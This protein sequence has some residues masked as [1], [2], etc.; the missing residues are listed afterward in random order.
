[1]KSN[2][3]G[4]PGKSRYQKKQRAKRGN[5]ARSPLWMSW[6]ESPAKPRPV[7]RAQ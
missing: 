7:A 3:E 5:G 2:N 6:F 4:K 1:M